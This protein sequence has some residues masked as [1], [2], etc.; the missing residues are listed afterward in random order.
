M[1]TPDFL[2]LGSG[3]AGLSFA[4]LMAKAGRSVRLIEA[5]EF[6]GGYGHSFVLA[7]KY[8]FNAQ[9]HYAWDCR[10]GEPVHR[11][12]EALGIADE[13]SFD[14]FDSAG[15]DRMRAPGIELDVPFDYQLLSQRLCDLFPSHKSNIQA[16]IRL[17]PWTG[18]SLNRYG[19]SMRKSGV[20]DKAIAFAKLRKYLRAT[21]QDVF[22][23]HNLP[24]EAQ[25]LLALR[26]PCF[27]L[28]PNR[29][30]FFAWVGL[31][32]G[33]HSGAC[34]VSGGFDQLI[35]RLVKII[36]DN[37]G[38]V[39]YKERVVSLP[40]NGDRISK[41][42]TQSVKSPERLAEY[43]GKSII[44][45]FDPK[46]AAEM[47]GLEK[48]SRQVQKRLDYDYSPSNLIAYCAVKDI[49]LKKLGFG[50][51][52]LYH[53]SEM[54]LNK[55]YDNMYLLGDYSKPSFAISTPSLHSEPSQHCPEGTHLI[56]FVTVAEYRRF[57]N[58]KVT[59]RREYRRKKKEIFEHIVCA[60]EKYHIPDLSSKI[61][62]DSTGSP[63]TNERYCLSPMGNSY[64]SNLTPRNISIFRLDEKTSF[65]NF[66]F[67]NASS[68]F[69]GFAGTLATGLRL[70]EILG[71]DATS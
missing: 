35:E 15:F 8:K 59:S 57:L 66:Y 65:S 26:W 36:N 61:C 51:S 1:K 58:L 62:F 31:V 3:L 5:H 13:I 19:G 11:L 10:P 43:Q 20:G 55:A 17:I 34:S 23:E 50:R 38:E 32:H 4:A 21:L 48:F 46:Q 6:P 47:I 45:N 9:L 54:D 49:D 18:R 16:F 39:I 22:D 30:S 53:T 33:Y 67:C 25:T 29:V 12:L 52:I 68:G 42:V 64:G 60:A 7:N 70:Y 56:E 28:P 71:A 40:V 44:C 63:T 14:F 27:M 37:G 24:L 69:A 2:V 41:V